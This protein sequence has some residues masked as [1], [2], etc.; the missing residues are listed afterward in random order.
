[1]VKAELPNLAGDHQ[2]M[3]N[4]SGLDAMDAALHKAWEK[5]SHPRASLWDSGLQITVTTPQGYGFVYK[6]SKRPN[7]MGDVAHTQASHRGGRLILSV[8]VNPAWRDEFEQMNGLWL[9]VPTYPLAAD[10]PP[11]AIVADD[12]NGIMLPIPQISYFISFTGFGHWSWGAWRH[13]PNVPLLIWLLHWLNVAMPLLV[14]A[15]M[16]AWQRRVAK[17]SLRESPFGSAQPVGTA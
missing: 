12:L 14:V 3:Q 1:M 4:A 8:P 17:R 6:A 9:E 5:Q 11:G 16:L 13:L 2:T 10:L 15:T 7:P